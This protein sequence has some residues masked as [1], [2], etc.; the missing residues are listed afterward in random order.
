LS[1]VLFALGLL[2]GMMALLEIGRRIGLRDLARDP[3][4]AG[5]GLG[6]LVGSLF[7]LMGLLLAFT[8]S[9]AGA[10]FDARRNLIVEEANTIGTAYLRISLLPS[11]SQDKLRSSFRE[12]LDS[13][14]SF[15]GNLADDSVKAQAADQR[16][17]DL[18][19]EI[20]KQAVEAT[21]QIG[22][23]PNASAVT[24]LVIQSINA[25]IDI[26]STRTVALTIHPPTAV[27]V[28]L[29]AVV[30][31]CCLLAGYESAAAKARSWLHLLGFTLILTVS[32]LVIL[33]Y[34]HPRYGFVRVDPADQVLR[35]LRT[36]MR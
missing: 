21:Q 25:M 6:P 16:A 31:L 32:I 26:K 4:H 33:D 22:A 23:A 3:D 1:S 7:G 12:Y 20:W 5:K 11:A 13:R 15:Y 2:A 28:M 18:L 30:M 14:L 9:G 34:E 8:F 36:S 17:I 29:V 24:S 10:R 35:D 27:Y 19:D